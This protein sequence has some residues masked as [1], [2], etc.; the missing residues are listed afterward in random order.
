MT[1]RVT[2]KAEQAGL[3]D[4]WGDSPAQHEAQEHDHL[5]MND[6]SHLV[7]GSRPF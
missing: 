4:G 2:G 6:F 1:W 5:L 7:P 3:C